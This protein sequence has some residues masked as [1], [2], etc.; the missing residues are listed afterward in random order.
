MGKA[1]EI[2]RPL[3]R[4]P[5]EASKAATAIVARL[6]MFS[7]PMPPP[8]HL[9]RYNSIVP[10]AGRIILDMAVKEQRHRHSMNRLEMVYPYL[11]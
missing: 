2:L 4:N 3:L 11:G 5:D 1:A 7:G 9:E 6:E 8:Q 10:G